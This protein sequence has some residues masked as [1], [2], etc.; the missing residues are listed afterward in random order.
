MEVTGVTP[1]EML[2]IEV[3]AAIPQECAEGA[4]YSTPT[5]QAAPGFVRPT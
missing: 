3:V 5:R 1:V 2:R 4:P